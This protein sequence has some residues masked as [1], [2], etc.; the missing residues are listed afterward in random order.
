MAQ[1]GQPILPAV[2]ASSG[3]DAL[4]GWMRRGGGAHHSPVMCDVSS[5]C[6]AAKDY[7]S[8]VRLW[9]EAT[10]WKYFRD[11]GQQTPGG[12]PCEKLRCVMSP[13]WPASHRARSPTWSTATPRSP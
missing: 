3:E 10:S 5:Y 12:H 7:A 2:M 4:S 8:A 9:Q 11:R 13:S 1:K 6:S